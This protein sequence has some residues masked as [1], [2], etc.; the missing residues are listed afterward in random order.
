[1]KFKIEI[2]K[3]QFGYWGSTELS[4]RMLTIE[5]DSEE[6]AREIASHRAF[7]DP[8]LAGKTLRNGDRTRWS[9]V[10]SD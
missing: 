3:T 10:S 7:T 9:V 4:R 2:K 5:A 8:K 6:K 1:M